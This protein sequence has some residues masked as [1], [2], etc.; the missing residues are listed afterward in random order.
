MNFLISTQDIVFPLS[1]GGS[2][3]TLFLGKELVNRG[4][5]VT[6]LVPG[7]INKYESMKV[8]RFKSFTEYNLP[9]ILAGVL[10]ATELFIKSFFYVIKTEVIIA[11]GPISLIPL[12]L[13][14]KIFKK[15]I[16]A[17]PTDI[18]SEY[19][20]YN[21]RNSLLYPFIKIL[22]KIE[23]WFIRQANIIFAVSK[24]MKK[25]LEERN[26]CKPIFVNYDGYNPILNV[27]SKETKKRKKEIIIIHHGSIDKFE[28]SEEFISILS[29]VLKKQRNVKVII[30]GLEKDIKNLKEDVK[31][32]KIEEKIIFP[33]WVSLNKLKELLIKA[34]IGV[35]I[36]KDIPGNHLVTTLKI[37]DYWCS[38]TIP[39]VPELKAIK[40]IASSKDVVYYRAGSFKDLEQKINK[41]VENISKFT[42]IKKRGLK[43]IHK[44]NFRKCIKDMVDIIESELKNELK[45]KR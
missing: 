28:G 36:K 20:L 25:Y 31:R 21:Y 10:S 45:N 43:K 26:I 32:S 38:R 13:W 35:V 2:L 23:I 3:R 27:S 33:G 1:G 29:N 9:K 7:N 5:N 16:I 15:Y 17:S 30:T 37:F 4:H 11:I 24:A 8:I 14:G 19:L 12:S 22:N 6:L 18:N 39:I 44:F 40:E 41:V 42:N 34:D